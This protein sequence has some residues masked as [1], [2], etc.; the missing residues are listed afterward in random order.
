MLNLPPEKR[1]IEE[2]NHELRQQ[3]DYEDKMEFRELGPN[4][5]VSFFDPRLDAFLKDE[6]DDDFTF[7]PFEA[8]IRA[9]RER[10]NSSVL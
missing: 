7:A 4:G 8:A 2:L 9:Y 10:R 1:A 6:R 5:S 3:P